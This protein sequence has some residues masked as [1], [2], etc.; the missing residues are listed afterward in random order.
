MKY[1][2]QNSAVETVTANTG[3]MGVK[4]VHHGAVEL[5]FR[6][7]KAAGNFARQV[8]S[9][10]VDNVVTVQKESFGPF[11]AAHGI[12]NFGKTHPQPFYTALRNE[13]LLAPQHRAQP[14]PNGDVL[15]YH[16]GREYD[17]FSNVTEI[18][19][20][21]DILGRVYKPVSSECVYQALKDK[22]INSQAAQAILNSRTPNVQALGQQLNYN[23]VYDTKC[24]SLPQNAKTFV[25][26]YYP[27]NDFTVKEEVMRQILLAKFTQNPA[28]LKALLE[29]GNRKIIEDTASSNLAKKDAFWGNA[30]NGRNAL[31]RILMAVR[32]Q[33]QDELNT[34]QQIRVRT[35]M[36]P[37]VLA[38]LGYTVLAPEFRV[39]PNFTYVPGIY[40]N[41]IRPV[42]VVANLKNVPA[43]VPQP[44]RTVTQQQPAAPFAQPPAPAKANTVNPVDDNDAPQVVHQQPSPSSAAHVHANNNNVPV[45]KPAPITEPTKKKTPLG[46]TLNV[47]GGICMAGAAGFV[48]IS[49]VLLFAFPGSIILFAVALACLGIALAVIALGGLVFGLAKSADAPKEEVVQAPV[50]SLEHQLS[51]TQTNDGPT[52][53]MKPGRFVGNEQQN[54]L[55]NS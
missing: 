46:S 51:K 33:L 13:I 53:G 43:F 29:T 22:N 39:E 7:S 10:F 11:F 5:T 52:S 17:I 19:F 27:N 30:N 18:P 37:D 25:A 41:S 35:K 48:A 6:T 45:T 42:T 23:P 32:D 44:A 9:Q 1:Q 2:Y 28:I 38:D 8:R 47:V 24:T 55:G 26:K 20:T 36:S 15:F 12:V 50:K 3:A 4:I 21:I 40:L 54:G 16:T 31:G 49:L 34:T 14:N